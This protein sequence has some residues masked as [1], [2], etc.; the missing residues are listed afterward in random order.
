MRKASW[1]MALEWQGWTD[2]KKWHA[3]SSDGTACYSGDVF[4]IERHAE[5]CI[6]GYRWIEVV[7]REQPVFWVIRGRFFITVHLLRMWTVIKIIIG[8]C[9]THRKR[10]VSCENVT[11]VWED[12]G[13]PP[14]LRRQILYFIL[15]YQKWN[16][17]D[18]FLVPLWATRSESVS[19]KILLHFYNIHSVE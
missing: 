2:A 7:T 16:A 11:K 8:N 18:G 12:T 17:G 19:S 1:N 3:I 15:I 9:E 4:Q 13:E 6:V 5:V 14:V 10:E